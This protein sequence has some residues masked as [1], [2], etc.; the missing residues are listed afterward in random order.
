M[1]PAEGEN[2]APAAP[3][4]AAAGVPAD[5][6][7][8]AAA[9]ARKKLSKPVVIGIVA[10]VAVIVAGLAAFLTYRSE[11]WGGKSL[12]DPASITSQASGKN[13]KKGSVVKAKDVTEALKAKGLKT[14]T[15]KVF[16]GSDA[17]VFVGYKGFSQGERVDAGST[18]TVQE[19]AGPGVPADTI[20]KDVNKVVSTFENMGVPVH[21]KQ[22]IVNDT[23]NTPAG[24]V[25]ATYPAAGQGVAKDELD[26]GIFVGVAT[27]GDGLGADIIG[28]DKDKVESDLE[29]QGYDV[30]MRPRFS[31][32]KNV[33]KITGSDPAPGSAMSEGDEITLYYGIDAKGVKEA[34]SIHNSPETGASTNMLGVS[35]VAS[36]TW[37]NNAGDCI[38]FD[39]KDS[40]D[41]LD[42][43]S[44]PYPTGK[45]GT[46][47]GEYSTLISCD[48]IQQ[49]YCS[50]SKAGYL[51]TG[52]TGA[53]ELMPGQSLTN[54]WC[55]STRVDGNSV[56][57]TTCD[58]GEYHM[59]DYFVV[60]P[61][62]ADLKS[63]ENDG[64][65]DKDALAAA[66]KQKSVDTDRPFLLYRDPKLYDKTTAARSM[67]NGMANSNPFLPYN[68]YGSGKDKIV[69]MK[70]AP[71]D[72]TAYYLVEQAGSYDWDD[73]PDAN[74]DTGS[75]KTKS[76][77]DKTDAKQSKKS[78]TYSED[79]IRSAVDDGDF[80][81]IA[82]TYCLKSDDSC[83][84]LDKSGTLKVK[85]GESP[86]LYS[87]AT[88]LT[89]R[90]GS[91]DRYYSSPEDAPFL[92]LT[93]PDSDYQCKTMSGE[94]L[95]GSDCLD[96][97]DVIEANITQRPL[98]PLYI[99]K[100]ATFDVADG[101]TPFN[102]SS[103]GDF[104]SSKP[105]LY[106]M[107]YH[108]NNAPTT[109]TVYYLQ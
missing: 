69:K 93:G 26:K 60:V 88:K 27:K 35:G 87:H 39:N 10:L 72:D 34:Y 85:D 22:V 82:G 68:G 51:L 97:M 96:S 53:F 101:G 76:S 21:Y 17:G 1:P 81:P 11:V 23:K 20:G 89:M 40:G 33:G 106:F 6:A 66:K 67:S 2:P 31:S 38:T 8:V 30:T 102:A 44:I 14:K 28:K 42:T 24:R 95:S 41:D 75:S 37:C 7:A 12:P 71:S 61:E 4:G 49:P 65:F 73:L 90:T 19:S 62:G 86:D 107:G 108:M 100:G 55:G 45:D 52:D 79:E 9:P 46:E 43:G 36:G 32:K 70:P 25:V 15:E 83:V 16:S 3:A 104:D 63:L 77:G 57:G 109:D 13:G 54:Y 84:T 78:K 80:T 56:G 5:A 99:F 105:C 58:D 64:F 91:W 94:S 50:N 59:Q 98:N 29:S 74:V 48:A 18:V 103:E 92:D 47:Y